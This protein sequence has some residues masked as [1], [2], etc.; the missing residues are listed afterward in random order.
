VWRKRN[1]QKD[2]LSLRRRLI[3]EGLVFILFPE[4]TRIRDGTMGAFQPGIGALV[5]GSGVP[6]VPCHLDG[7]FDAWPAT[8]SLPRPAP[9]RLRIGVPLRFD[10]L[11]ND[12]AGWEAVTRACEAAVRALG[13]AGAA[14]ETTR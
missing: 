1:R 2:L 13:G 10:D 4:G 11:A 12:R 6:V 3:D 14:R 9:L 5:A 8:R 7:A